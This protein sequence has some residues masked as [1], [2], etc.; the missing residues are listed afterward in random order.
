MSIFQRVKQTIVTNKAI[1]EAGGYNVIPWS[2]PRLS[3]I[4]PGVPRAKYIIVTANSKVK[5]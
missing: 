4:L 3:T 5:L 2:L 1:R